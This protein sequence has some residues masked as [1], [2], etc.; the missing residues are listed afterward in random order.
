[1]MV[2]FTGYIDHSPTRFSTPGK[3]S[4]AV[5]VDLV[6]LDQAG[7]DGYQGKVYRQVWW[8]PGRLIQFGKP[9]LGRAN[10]VLARMIKGEMVMGNYPYELEL[11]DHDP[12]CVAR[13]TAWFQA[14]PGFRPTPPQSNTAA[15]VDT[16]PAPAPAQRQPSQLEQFAQSRIPATPTE[17]RNNLREATGRPPV[18]TPPPPPPPPMRPGSDIPDSE[19]PF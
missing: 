8:R 6:D 18:P 1:M 11:V 15:E 2:W 5:V 3:K 13:G 19:I 16:T 17:H 9:R 10:P 12:D 4:D 14:N 7:D